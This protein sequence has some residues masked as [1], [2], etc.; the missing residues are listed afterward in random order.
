MCGKSSRMALLFLLVGALMMA[1][2]IPVQASSGLDPANM[3]T[4]VDPN[5][6][7]YHYA[8]GN[9]LKNNPI[10]GDYS[11]WGS[12]EQ[13]A[14]E[15]YKVLHEI[16]ENAANDKNAPEGSSVRKIGDFFYSGMDTV[17]INKAGV[18]PL[19][20]DFQRINKIKNLSD[21][22]NT[23]AYF[24]VIG[25][26]N[27]FEFFADQDAKN[28]TMVIA[29]LYQ[30]GLGLPDR[31]Y[32]TND[33]ERSKEIRA[34]YVK[35]V[36]KMFELLGDDAASAEAY[37]NTVMAIE[38][39]LAKASKTR[40]ELRDPEGQ[41]HK[42]TVSDLQK[43]TPDFNWTAYFTNIGLKDPGDIIVGQPDFFKE[44]GNM[45]KEVSLD[46]WKTYLRWH[47]IHNTANFLSSDF[48]N[49]SFRFYGTFLSGR[50]RMQDR[51]KRVLRATNGSLGEA[52]S[53][54]YVAKVFPPEAKERAYHIVMNLKD[55]L[56]ERI[57]NLTWMSDETKQR[58]LEKLDAFGVKIGYPDKWI[59]YSDV[60]ISRD[61]YLQNVKNAT[62][63]A[64]DRDLKKIGEPVDR[65]EWHMLA[66]T[67][68]AYYNPLMNEIVFPA[69]IL[70]PPFF[71]KDAD[72]AVNYGA[73]G[74]VIG[75]EMTH[76]FDD[77]GR[78]YSADGNLKDWWTQA[79]AEKF[80]ARAKMLAEQYDGYVVV[81]SAHVDGA[82]TQ[83]ENIADL[84]GLTIAYTALQK[85]LKENGN[86]GKIDGFTPAQR[87]FLSWAQIWRNN[88]RD[89]ELLL[90]LKTDV[91]SPGS[92]RVNGPMAN[93]PAFQQAFEGKPGSPM[94]RPDSLRIVIW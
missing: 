9:W 88:I 79:D 28:S 13:L 93:M 54:L 91:H 2:T 36:T 77:Q 87:F 16:L 18:A 71:S 49:E 75:H 41:Y 50:P 21:F 1:I 83:G 34:E 76:G 39:R 90:R 55:A 64:F 26:S 63:A 6:D 66:Q 14:E 35:H 24:H 47:L 33:D 15:N 78:K 74:A 61:N 82:L 72:D 62:V 84:G 69:A 42:M 4:K 65:K 45:Q 70:Q 22:Q 23:V 37:A 59:D 81:D 19:A 43:L 31:D 3:D 27:L 58:A 67:V 53:Q 44:M 7:F 10:P 52:L 57:K 73:M 68:N 30:G 85:A 60:E 80:N 32:Y 29:Q 12:F 56:R 86:P 48:V 5:V 51:W 17:R 92:V 94:V 40:L 8:N 46:N 38:T 20:E 89:K 25:V 11:R